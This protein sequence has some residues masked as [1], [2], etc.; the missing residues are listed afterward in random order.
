MKRYNQLSFSTELSRLIAAAVVSSD[1]C[2]L[3][4]RNPSM[5]LA[6][7]YGGTKFTLSPS[8]EALVLSIN[9]TTLQAFAAEMVDHVSVLSQGERRPL[10]GRMPSD[11]PAMTAAPGY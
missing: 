5:A 3:L 11:V 9:A 8:E 4:L 1:F 7:G 10:A 6:R 2:A